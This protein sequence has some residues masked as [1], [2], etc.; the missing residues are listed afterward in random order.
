MPN[1]DFIRGDIQKEFEK[2]QLR[3]LVVF[4]RNGVAD[5]DVLFHGAFNKSEMPN[6]VKEKSLFPIASQSKT[7]TAVAIMQLVEKD[8]LDLDKELVE[9]LP[10]L[11][12][13]KLAGIKLRNVLQHRSPILWKKI[14]GNNRNTDKWDTGEEPFATTGELHEIGLGNLLDEDRLQNWSKDPFQYSNL[15][16]TL[17]GMVIEKAS[18]M[19]YSEYI[20]Q[21]ILKPHG[22]TEVYSGLS[23]EDIERRT[24]IPTGYQVN[25]EQKN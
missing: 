5:S 14:I 10:G 20:S 16:Y 22:L 12:H 18:G 4:I 3:G 21:N 25:K 11:S 13:P 17:L 15:G 9:Y 1:R 6:E 7:F 2:F 8:L 19:P 23:K 24:D